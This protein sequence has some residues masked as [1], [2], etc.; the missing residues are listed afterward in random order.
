MFNKD[1]LIIESQNDFGCGGI[2]VSSMLLSFG[3]MSA[4]DVNIIN[5]KAGVDGF[6]SIQ[7]EI[8]GGDVLESYL[9]D[10]L[11]SLFSTGM[12]ELIAFALKRILIRF[13]SSRKQNRDGELYFHF[14]DKN[15][16]FSITFKADLNGGPE[17]VDTIMSKMNRIA[18]IIS[19]NDEETNEGSEEKHEN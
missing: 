7:D 18:G 2:T 5:R 11:I 10:I 1:D 9:I 16:D 13:K 15:N 3:L 19:D 6:V 17:Q 8:G 4:E 12:Y 14:S